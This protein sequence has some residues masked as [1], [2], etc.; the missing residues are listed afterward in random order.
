MK[1][2][3][4]GLRLALIDLLTQSP[5]EFLKTQEET[6]TDWGFIECIN[7]K[8]QE[9]KLV[10]KEHPLIEMYVNGIQQNRIE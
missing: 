3:R 10:F 6:E 8:G 2:Q 9:I 1:E 5:N 4:D 7:D